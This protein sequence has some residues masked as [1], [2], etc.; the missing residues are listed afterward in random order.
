MNTIAHF[1]LK[2]AEVKAANVVEF[3]PTAQGV[4]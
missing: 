2:L 1:I 3:K 4:E